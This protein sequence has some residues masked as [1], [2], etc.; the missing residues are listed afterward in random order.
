MICTGLL[1]IGALVGACGGDDSEGST[2]AGEGSGGAADLTVD[3]LDKLAFDQDSY[4]VP[5]GEVQVLYRNEGSLPHTLVIEGVDGFKLSVGDEDS[6]SVELEPGSY[7]LYCDVAGHREAG[8]EA[9]L[10]VS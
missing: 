7:V 10:T 9:E 6:G 2:G 8:M 1:A 3:A 5:A 4:E